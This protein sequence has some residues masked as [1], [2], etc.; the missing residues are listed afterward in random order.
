MSLLIYGTVTSIILA[1]YAVGFSL[2]YGISGLA[3]F[4]HGALYILSGFAA[5]H[6]MHYLGLPFVAA[7]PLTVL[8]AGLMG[9]A[10]YWSLLIRVRGIAVSEL[11]V[12]FAAGVAILELLT[13]GGFYGTRYSLPILFEEGVEIAGVVIDGQRLLVIV[14]GVMLVFLLYLFV[15]HTKTGLAFR[16]MAQDERTALSVGIESDWIGSLSLALGS[17]LAAIA[18]LVVLP[19]GMMEAAVGYE[20]LIYALAVAIVG[21]LEST[22]GMVVAGFII[23]FG[24]SAAARYIGPKWMV[25]VPLASIVL[26]LAVRPSGLLGRFKELEERV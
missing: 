2:T 26:V 1:L 23:G 20:V 3:N 10:M 25:I 5:W 17:A 18:A 6:L 19:L 4:A 14:T 7:I 9:F 13:W 12:T 22:T 21:G 8:A 11:I 24:Q 16:G 15:H